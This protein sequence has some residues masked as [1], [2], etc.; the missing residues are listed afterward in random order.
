MPLFRGNGERPIP[1]HGD[2]RGE[3]F[4]IHLSQILPCLLKLYPL[5][6]PTDMVF[7]N[8]E[9]N[10]QN[11]GQILADTYPQISAL[12]GVEHFISRL[13]SDVANIPFIKTF[14]KTKYIH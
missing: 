6:A 8:G 10:V 13:F 4:H 1:I 11:S 9:N 12:H 3:R 5:K 2:W 14:I 7:F